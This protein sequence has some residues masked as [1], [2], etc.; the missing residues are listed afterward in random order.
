MAACL[1]RQGANVEMAQLEMISRLCGSPCPSVWPE[2]VRLP[3]WS[4][5]RPKKPYRRRLKEEFWHMPSAAL[6]LM[7]K[8]LELDPEKRISAKDALE[9]PWLKSVNPD[10]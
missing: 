1:D 10:R 4:T 3:L 9:S 7:D 5:L 6:S 8:M 2:V